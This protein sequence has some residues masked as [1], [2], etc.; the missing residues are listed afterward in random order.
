MIWFIA[1][2]LNVI[3]SIICYL[4]NWLV[5]LFAD[6]RGELHGLWRLWQTW[7]DTLD[8]DW[9]VKGSVPKWLRYDFDKHYVSTRETTDMLKIYNRDKGAVISL[10]VPWTRKERL[11]RYICRVLWLTRNCGYGFAF[12]LF[13]IDHTGIN[14]A[15]IK[16]SWYDIY[17][18]DFCWQFTG[19]LWTAQIMAGWKLDTDSTK[20]TRSMIAGRIIFRL[21]E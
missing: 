18:D 7:D 17:Y 10:G 15:H 19:K 11:Q 20:R 16:G 5:V 3:C 4:T 6:E 1:F 9:F 14:L 8:V 12:W 21:E 13:G 2:P